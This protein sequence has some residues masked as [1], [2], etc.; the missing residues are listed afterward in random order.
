MLDRSPLFKGD[1]AMGWFRCLRLSISLVL[2]ATIVGCGQK[3][4]GIPVTGIVTIDGAPVGG[5]TVT[6][7]PV[8]GQGGV[9]VGM[10]DGSGRFNLSS[11]AGSG[12][13]PG[14]YAVTITKLA[15]PSD[16][17]SGPDPREMGPNIT[18]EQRQKILEGA[19]AQQTAR[20]ATDT[21]PASIPE[22]Y[23]STETSGFA[24][25]VEQGGKNDF[26]FEMTSQ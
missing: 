20:K 1:V 11:G 9:A 8:G 4:S 26:T 14:S 10:T 7:T 3:P 19:Q 2:L 16:T 5:A 12:A 21:G 13:L 22:R 6:F 25:V 23:S 18:E 17:A 15:R 24:A